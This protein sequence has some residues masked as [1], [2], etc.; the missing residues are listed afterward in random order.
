MKNVL[1]KLTAFICAAAIMVTGVP[2]SLTAEAATS[3]KKIKNAYVNFLKSEIADCNY[4][5]NITYTLYDFNK[6]GVKELIVANPGGVRVLYDVYTYRNNKI[7]SLMKGGAND[8]GYLPGK[9]YIVA[10]GSGGAMLHGYNVYTIKKG[11]LKKVHSYDYEYGSYKKDGKASDV[12][13]YMAFSQKVVSLPV[14]TTVPKKYTSPAKLGIS[15]LPTGKKKYL[16]LTKAT[17]KKIY[18]RYYTL[19]DEQMTTWQ[20]KIKSAKITDKTEF[21]YGDTSL[22]FSGKLAGTSYDTKKWIQKISKKQFLE[23]MK[24][25]YGAMEQVVV[26][27]GKAVKVII[28]IQI[29]G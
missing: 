18:Y 4:D 9:K 21:Y 20:S 27:N 6:D 12:D 10:Y 2:F 16:D 11:K 29:A 24:T 1:K 5:E 23:K 3:A 13:T 26:K 25:Y 14:S 7:V 22:L 15:V 8:I 19:G 17:N 28:H